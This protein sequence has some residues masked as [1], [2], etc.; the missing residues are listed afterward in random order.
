MKQPY[1]E[2]EHDRQTNLF[3]LFYSAV[4]ISQ[5]ITE[6]YSDKLRYGTEYEGI[7]V[8]ERNEAAM[9]YKSGLY[10]SARKL[11]HILFLIAGLSCFFAHGQTSTGSGSWETDANWSGGVA[12]P[13]AI[14]NET[15]VI[16]TGNPITRNG[17]LRFNTNSDGSITANADF[18][19]TQ[20]IVWSANSN[21]A[22][23]AANAV[24]IVEGNLILENNAGSNISIDIGS[25][26]VLLIQGDLLVSN[27][28]LNGIDVTSGGNLVVGGDFDLGSGSNITNNG[29]IYAES[30]SGSASI[31]GTGGAVKS[32]DDLNAE[33][34]GL[35]SLTSSCTTPLPVTLLWFDAEYDESEVALT[36]ST[37]TEQNNEFFTLER[38]T[39]GEHFDEIATV[40][41]AGITNEASTYIHI[42]QVHESFSGFLY[43]RLS[44]TDYD[45][46]TEFFDL[47]SV[48]IDNARSDLLVYPNPLSAHSSVKITGTTI[49]SS[50]WIYSIKGQLM[51]KGIVG[52]TSEISTYGLRAGS[53]SLK[54]QHEL[55]LSEEFILIVR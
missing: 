13:T 8:Q 41:G 44:Q 48:W 11:K 54:I 24:F 28:A 10:A 27:G 39:D 32:I 5:N 35:C 17:A 20:D 2:Q 1:N 45:G 38:S 4:R 14:D 22:S 55:G 53:Y 37:A 12:P 19:I 34:P 43:Y 51:K 26:G 29:N 7:N 49:N 3:Q 40:T 52:S 50:W 36:W 47:A 21:N 25:G 6:G 46:T 16:S 42:D 33:N 30:T 9:I 23:I 31:T 15:I 18:I